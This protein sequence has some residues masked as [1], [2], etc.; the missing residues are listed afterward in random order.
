MKREI[1]P[2]PDPTENYDDVEGVPYGENPVSMGHQPIGLSYPGGS[3]DY[4]APDGVHY[5][6]D[7]SGQFGEQDV[8][9]NYQEFNVSL[10]FCINFIY[11]F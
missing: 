6:F 5:D 8:K 7:M 9:M 11:I 3:T 4:N 10:Q 2:D 1:I